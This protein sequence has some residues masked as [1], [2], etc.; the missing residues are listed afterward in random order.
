MARRKFEDG[1]KERA[2]AYCHEHPEKTMKA[3]AADLDIGYSTLRRWVVQVEEAKA[4]RTEENESV[5]LQETAAEDATT[6]AAVNEDH[7]DEVLAIES[8]EPVAADTEAEEAMDAEEEVQQSV[9]VADEVPEKVE[10]PLE[11]ASVSNEAAQNEEETPKAAEKTYDELE[12]ERLFSS[13]GLSMGSSAN[14]HPHDEDY[15]LRCK[16]H[17]SAYKN[18]QHMAG[19]K[20]V[21]VSAQ[22]GNVLEDISDGV[23]HVASRL[24]L[25]KKRHDLK[26]EQKLLKKEK[27]KRLKR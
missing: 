4:D 5:V 13:I 1:F 17:P 19:D 18:I 24:G 10:E 26:K 7:S 9:E 14:V 27:E 21:S 6:A 3:C 20:I 16:S 11:S 22:I 2:V 12:D 8:E 25:Y 15:D 23:S